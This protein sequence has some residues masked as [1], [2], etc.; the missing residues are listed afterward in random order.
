MLK[1][2]AEVCSVPTAPFAEQFMVRYIEH[3]VAARPKL[4]LTR[5]AAGNL[6]IEL[7][8]KERS[9]R[10]RG[11]RWIFAAHLDHPGFVA[12]KMVDDRTLEAAFRGWVQIDY[13]RGTKVRFF[14]E[15]RE[16]AG[17]I[18]DATSSRYDR[19]TVA[20]RVK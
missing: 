14:D 3:F 11:P 4:R 18:I 1:L 10:G 20:D 13:V 6:L 17:V 7:P 8:T 16:I 5:D 2:L 12:G 9:R 15:D 19:L